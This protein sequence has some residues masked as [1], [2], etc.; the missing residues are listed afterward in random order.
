MSDP[1]RP[2]LILA[3]VDG[4]RPSALD[5]AIEQGLAP[6]HALLRARGTATE[7]AAAFPSVTPTCAAAIATGT[8]QDHHRIP[9][10]N[11]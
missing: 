5:E 1:P 10:I 7:A 9:A 3:V 8:L 11:W 6:V 4:L 2:K